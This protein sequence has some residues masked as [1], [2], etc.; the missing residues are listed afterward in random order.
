MTVDCFC[1][2]DFSRQA[3]AVWRWYNYVESKV[4][5][6]K[7]ILRL[8]MDETSISLFQ[9]G[10]T[11]NVF[12]PSYKKCRQKA[13]LQQRRACLTHVAII[14][15]DSSIQTKLP[16]YV[17]GNTRIFKAR[18][19]EELR[20]R[21]PANVFL[22][23]Q[24]SAWNN[25]GLCCNIIK[26]L[27]VALAPYADKYQPVLLMDACRVHFTKDVLL[28]CRR[29]RIWVICIPPGTTS[30]LQPL[31]THAFA[32][33]K[34]CMRSAYQRIHC[35]TNINIMGVQE[36]LECMYVA[37][38]KVLQGVLWRSAFLHNGFGDGQCS[39]SNRVLAK[40]GEEHVF[41]NGLVERPT[42]AVLSSCCP[43]DMHI[44]MK[45]FM[46]PFDWGAL[47]DMFSSARHVC[48]CFSRCQP[49]ASALGGCSRRCVRTCRTIYTT[50]IHGTAL[51]WR[52]RC[53]ARSHSLAECN[54]QG[55][56]SWQ[57]GVADGRRVFLFAHY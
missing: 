5:E 15:D 28:A 18:T 53:N 46:W 47:E 34:A 42:V 9:G 30:L 44:Q 36:I 43:R 1:G 35:A 26:Q 14:C 13:T 57:R 31:D 40:F 17:V 32:R 38:R 24:K 27:G 2:F 19:F 21:A 29:A 50:N 12:M 3:N 7:Q 25:S 52:I 23:R 49:C 41:S 6:A 56:A 45:L 55:I 37:I 8:N 20:T 16:Q 51:A 39:V 4:D 48:F 54:R 11:G 22:V 10:G 33:Y